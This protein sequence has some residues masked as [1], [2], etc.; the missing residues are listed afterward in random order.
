MNKFFAALA[1]SVAVTASGAASAATVDFTGAQPQGGGAYTEDGL[2]FDNI[3]IVNGNCNALSG[4]GCGAYNKNEASVLTQVGGGTFSLTSFWY[5]LLGRGS[6]G[7]KKFVANTFYV[8]SNLGGLLTFAANAVGNND[9]GHVVDLSTLALFQNV[10]SLTFSTNGG[11]NVRLD[12]LAIAPAP[13]PLPAAGLMLLAGIGGL[14]GLRKR[15]A[16]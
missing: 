14:V 8:A 3:R 11:G 7:G 6:G 10:S 4:A 5:E 9:G 2:M 12:D 15:K 13:V 1:M 16:A